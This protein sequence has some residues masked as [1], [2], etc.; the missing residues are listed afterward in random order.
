MTGRKGY[1]EHRDF[2][3]RRITEGASYG[4]VAAEVGCDKK[5]VR[6]WAMRAGVESAHE[7]RSPERRRYWVNGECLSLAQIG[8]RWGISITTLTERVRAGDT[9]DRLVRPVQ[10]QHRPRFY[11]LGIPQGEWEK[12]AQWAREIGVRRVEHKTRL[13]FGAI[14]AAMRG[15]WELLG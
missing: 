13:P 11:D 1:R 4:R 12:Y 14:A 8:R 15:E 5:T 10:R 7:K 6:H 3:A 9:G 2:I